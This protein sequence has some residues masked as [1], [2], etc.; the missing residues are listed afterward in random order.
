MADVTVTH[1]ISGSKGGVTIAGSS[2]SSVTMTGTDMA[3]NTTLFNASGGA[4]V[5]VPLG[6][7]TAGGPITIKNNESSAAAIL[8]LSLDNAFTK[9]FGEVWPGESFSGRVKSGQLWYARSQ[10]AVLTVNAV[11]YTV[12]P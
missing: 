1:S 7:V 5:A 8:L 4:V 6:S 11:T 9:V 3:T 12:D 10:D 2:S